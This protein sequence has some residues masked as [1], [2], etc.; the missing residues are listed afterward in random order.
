MH[1]I[2]IV[3]DEERFVKNLESV[4]A[5]HGEEFSISLA[6]HGRQAIE[7]LKTRPVDLVIT[8]I[9]MPVMDGFELLAYLN[10]EHPH[11]PAIVMTA[12]GNSHV[13]NRVTNLGAARYLEKPID[14]ELLENSIFDT[15]SVGATGYLE[16]ITLTTFLQLVEM[17]GKTCTISVSHKSRNGNV[18]CVEGKIIDAVSDNLVG[19]EA[20]QAMLLLRGATLSILDKCNKRERRIHTSIQKLLGLPASVSISSENNVDNLA[21][22]QLIWRL[23]PLKVL[24]EAHI[25]DANG[26][27]VVR[28]GAKSARIFLSN[29]KIAWIVNGSMGMTFSRF[30][31]QHAHLKSEDLE[32]VYSEARRTRRN[33]GEVIV[34]W[35]LVAKDALRQHLLEYNAY[36]LLDLFTWPQSEAMFIPDAKVFHGT[37]TFDLGEILRSM[38]VLDKEEKLP[39]VPCGITKDKIAIQPR[40]AF[41]GLGDLLVLNLATRA[42]GIISVIGEQHQGEVVVSDGV[43]V[44]AAIDSNV[45][46]AAFREIAKMGDAVLRTRVLSDPVTK[47]IAS[48]AHQLL[49]GTVVKA[50][51]KTTESQ[52][53]TFGTETSVPTTKEESMVDINKIN[54]AVAYLKQQLGEGL[55]ATDI[56]M[57]ADGQSIAGYNSNHKACALFN[58]MTQFLA[59]T[60]G[61]SGF[62]ALNRYYLMD[63]VDNKMVVV[64]PMGAYQWGMLIDTS[65]ATMGLLLNVVLPESLGMAVE[66]LK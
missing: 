31:V 38:L 60:L 63:L 40:G 49:F 48:H 45:G 11:I 29:N 17:E 61:R 57:T 65:K 7:L 51:S 56:F 66:A 8:D 54:Q 62:P 14:I 2:L 50:V 53:V 46:E 37:L 27:V 18:F 41:L 6:A 23:L 35:G 13:E 64:A 26:E 19:Q 24:Y 12:F 25:N 9:K 21:A 3:D 55:M 52:Q 32:A 15:L 39:F 42:K 33:F 34:D 1:H 58:Q 47:T 10:R 16:G 44:H 59:N 4:L 5:G 20:L 28:C 43:I 36:S 30:L 22:N